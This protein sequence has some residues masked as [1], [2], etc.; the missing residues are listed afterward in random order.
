MDSVEV[1]AG[2]EAQC[3]SRTV[4]NQGCSDSSENLEKLEQCHGD[5]TPGSIHDPD[6]LLYWKNTLKAN[7]WVMDTLEF[8]Y[9]LPLLSVPEQYEEQNNASATAH[10]DFVRSEIRKLTAQGVVMISKQKPHCVSPLTVATRERADGQVKRRLCWDGSRHINLL[11]QEQKVK[12]SH[13]SIALET[14][15]QGDFQLKYDLRNAFH[16]I[17]IHKNHTKYLGAAYTD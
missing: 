17:K 16:H 1:R 7:Q 5:F 9:C 10:M 11:L 13:L 15:M 8:G 3:N 2:L 4:K 6:K 14:T 12:L